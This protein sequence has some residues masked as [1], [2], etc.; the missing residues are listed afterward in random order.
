MTTTETKTVIGKLPQDAYGQFG[1]SG[2]QMI[3]PL[4][5]LFGLIVGRPKEGKSCLV[6]SNGAGLVINLDSSSTTTPKVNAQIWP[7][8]HRETGDPIDL[9]GK[10]M[11]MTWERLREV[12]DKLCNDAANGKPVPDTI[13][14]DSLS[15]WINVLKE[16]LIRERAGEVEDRLIERWQ[17]MDGRRYWDIL[18]D[19]II[20]TCTKLRQHGFGVWV[21]CHVID[22]KVPIK[23][24]TGDQYIIRP[25]LNITD[26]F[27]K[28][29]Y[30]MFEM[31]GCVEKRVVTHSES[32]EQKEVKLKGGEMYTP[33]ARTK[34]TK[35]VKHFFTTDND[36]LKGIV[37]QRVKMPGEIELPR[38]DGWSVVASAYDAAAYV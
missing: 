33:K 7:G 32:I 14:F 12:K 38:V 1:F 27:Y 36:E 20:G 10:A 37:G 34:H 22:V 25:E 19:M 5:R 28:R 15:A 29:L 8:I 11:I 31:V 16:Y 6:Q 18:Y 4:S 21:I 9:D 23:S 24:K 17:D 35:V 2:Q 3:H 30:P 26:G 13:Y